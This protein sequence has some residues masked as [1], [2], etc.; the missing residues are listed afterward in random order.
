MIVIFMFIARTPKVSTQRFHQGS[1]IPETP[2]TPQDALVL[3][4]GHDGAITL[5]HDNLNLHV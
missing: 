3:N 4:V 2:K 5:N 1:E